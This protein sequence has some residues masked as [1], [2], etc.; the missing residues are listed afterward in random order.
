MKKRIVFRSLVLSVFALLVLS[1]ASA[2]AASP[3]WQVL[4]G[5]RPTN[6]WEPE[7]NVQAIQAG[8][9]VTI[10]TLEG[11]P[12]A[13]MFSPFCVFFGLTNSET[14]L[15]LQEALEAP[16]AYGVGNVQVK[17]EPEAS[18]RFIITSVGEDAG[19]SVPPLSVFG[20]GAEAKILH[21]GGSGR[22]ILTIT[23]LGDAPADGTA[24]PITIEDQL[25]D[26][27]EATGFEA[28]AGPEGNPETG[29]KPQ[30]VDCTVVSGQLVTCDYEKV[31]KAYEAIEVEIFAT[32]TGEPP[33]AGAPGRVTVAGGGAPSMS[34]TQTVKASPVKAPFGIEQFSVQAE[35]EGGDAAKKAGSHP[36]QLTTTIQL[37]AGAMTPSAERRNA[38][39]EQPGLP[40]ALRFT[41]PA[42]L[43]GV[44]KAVPMCPNKEFLSRVEGERNECGDA[45]AIGVVAAT[46][47]ESATLG[48]DRL[49]VPLFNLSP[50]PGEPARFGFL[51]AGVPVEI[52]TAVDPDNQYRIIAEVRNITQVAELLSSTV[53]I[54]GTPGDP[55]HDI[56]R[57]WS[58]LALDPNAGP[59]QRPPGLEEPAFLRQP[60]ACATPMD[61]E[62]DAEPWNTPIGSVVDER[63]F[64]SEKMEACNQVPFNPEVHASPTDHAADGSSGL[65]F[66]L[67]MPNAGL[68]N[69]DAIAEGQAKKV[70]VT[71]PEGMT[72][73]PSQAE[74][75]GACS[76]AQYAQERFDSAPGAGCPESSKI[77]SVDIT[78]PLLDEEAHGS[79]YVAAPYDNPFG[80]LLALYMVAKIPDR[81]I[82]VKQAGEVKLNPNTGQI[83]TTFD[84]LPQIPFESFKLH[85]FEGN[86]APLV[87][88]SQC[89]S[90]DIVT[91]FTPW[92]AVDPDNPLAS[93]VIT[94]TTPFTIDQGCPSGPPPFAPGFVA[95]TQNNAA[96]KYSPFT[97]R[98]T[99]NDGEQEFSRFSL[100]LPKGVIGKLAGIPLCSAAAIAAARARTGP[101]GGQEELDSPSCPAASQIGRTSVGAGVGSALSYAP[102]KIYLAGR[103]QGS[104][105]SVVAITTAKVGPFDLGTVVIRQ[106]LKVD[107]ETAEVSTDGSSSDPIP[108]ILQGI[109]THARDIRIYVDRKNFVLNPTSCQRMSARATVVGSGVDVRVPGDDQSVDVSSPFQ[110]ADCASLGF[111][112]KLKLTL[113]GGT[114]R[115]DTP[116]LKAVLTARKGDANIGRA[117]V[118]LPPSAFLEQ[119]HIRTICTRVQFQ[120]GGGNGE[121][122]PKA[123]IYGRARAISPLLDEPLV[124]PVFL[125]SSNH[126]LPDLVAAL[127]SKKVD[128]D[129]VGRIDSLNGRIRNTFESVPDAP[130]TKF[131][132]EMQGG[133]KGLIV[134]STN[135]CRGKHRAIADFRGQNGRRHLFKP[136]VQAKCGKKRG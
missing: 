29:G 15:Q 87:M 9:E 31:L 94:K 83:T 4:T 62:A 105:L 101:N 98:L 35:E 132:L 107:P 54:W 77:G 70:E 64:I 40:R 26:G 122:C 49:S 118:T 5:S 1:S 117:Q 71:L 20:A 113:S 50:A 27:V 61:F 85:F 48:F 3:W 38:V 108:H 22:L 23:N 10:I 67:D 106:A 111:K 76:P 81:G 11:T 114:K 57:G 39:V 30:P 82:L 78:T 13:C 133:K 97:A 116:K 46:V 6:M 119:G 128:I 28:F 60:V 37:N 72:I 56:S 110:A 34:V 100:K 92:H 88:P 125:R 109:V 17:E 115:S 42:G 47:V 51:T 104:K 32:L 79:V 18:R 90:Y 126:E 53:T 25:P 63:E 93:E 136:V 45:T 112:P 135:I 84:D 19:R 120:A 7:D 16:A 127:H 86:R 21:A 89:G 102:G 103:Y 130:V 91:R 43:V 8:P 68:L 131:V 75:L 99:R 121:R 24:T 66:Q 129:L 2:S 73:N 33:V 52:D 44:A 74:G 69:K 58:C 95:G 59:C 36:F 55:R 65:D 41:L 134:N 12:V 123:S 80:S 14:A 124:G 96:G